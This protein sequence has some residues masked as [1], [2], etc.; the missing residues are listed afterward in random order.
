MA[1][2]NSWHRVAA[3]PVGESVHC[4]CYQSDRGLYC[5][6]KEGRVAW[7][8][9]GASDSAPPHVTYLPLDGNVLHVCFWR[10]HGGIL[11]AADNIGKVAV[12]V[13]NGGQLTEMGDFKATHAVTALHV[14]G[15][16]AGD[17]GVVAA[18][19][20]GL[21][22]SY[23]P[24]E[25]EWRVDLREWAAAGAEPCMLSLVSVRRALG[26]PTGADDTAPPEPEEVV[27][28]RF[29]LG[30]CTD[31]HVYGITATGLGLFAVPMPEG[32]VPTCAVVPP[33]Y[34]T[35][36]D[37]WALVTADDGFV[38]AL[39]AAPGGP[40]P[41]EAAPFANLDYPLTHAAAT[42]RHLVCIGQHCVV[43]VLAADGTVV[44][45]TGLPDWPVGVAVPESDSGGPEEVAVAA[46]DTVYVFRGVVPEA[47]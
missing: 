37:P 6:L 40:A 39:R 5:G 16:A 41:L 9:D 4:L 34:S 31:G 38:Y 18:D 13:P 42:A 47:N 14:H 2:E 32:T 17:Y 36:T 15:D 30:A 45:S 44:W 29:L 21:L 20:R 25:T 43:T 11:S 7:L 8:P 3:H 35:P 19:L 23:A 22:L 1:R 12:L 10:A 46:G 27:D 28:D 26:P 24:F 33:W